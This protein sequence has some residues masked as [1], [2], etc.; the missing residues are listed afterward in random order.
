MENGCPIC[1]CVCNVEATFAECSIYRC[2]NCDHCFTDL[3]VI[4]DGASYSEDYYN[5]D[6]KKWFDNPNIKLFDTIGKIINGKIE[7]RSLIEIG[8]GKGDFLRYV[9]SKNHS[10]DLTGIDFRK[11]EDID[12]IRFVQG[13]AFSIQYAMKYDIVV[14]LAVIEHMPDPHAYVDLL[15]NICAANG[16]IIIMTVNDRS[17]LYKISRLLNRLGIDG[18]YKRLYA[19]HHINHFNH[20]SLKQLIGSHGLVNVRTI[21]HNVPFT[22]IDTG[23]IPHFGDVFVRLG[24]MMT[25][26]FGRITGRT[27]LQTV[28]CKKVN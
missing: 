23:V 27:Y 15:K 16:L 14:T 19:K 26:L 1:G 20:S 6:H 28:I 22:A 18:P 8:C 24:I 10:L 21:N 13:D 7:K 12:G 11:N 9:R 17:I 2:T 25:F 3:K 4:N 5:F